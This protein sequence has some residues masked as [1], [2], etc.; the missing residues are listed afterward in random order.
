MVV[1]HAR[2][3]VSSWC[4]NYRMTTQNNVRFIF[5]SSCLFSLEGLRVRIVVFNATFNNISVMSWRS[6]FFM[7][8]TIEGFSTCISFMPYLVFFQILIHAAR[9]KLKEYAN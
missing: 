9:D 4:Y 6:D 5:T 3:V 1:S 7:E 8:K 2:F